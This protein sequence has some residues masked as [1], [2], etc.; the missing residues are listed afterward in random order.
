MPRARL[1]AAGVRALESRATLD[2]FENAMSQ[3]GTNASPGFPQNQL[4]GGTYSYNPITRNRVLLEYAYRG[5]WIVRKCIDCI[6]EDMTRE[7][8]EF[9][10]SAPPDVVEQVSQFW[11]EWGIMQQLHEGITWG[12]LYGGAIGIIII[13]GQDIETRLYPVTV[14]QNQFKGLM[15]LDR[16]MIQPTL[17]QLVEEPGPDF[18][19]PMYYDIYTGS[20]GKVVGRVH[21]TRVIRFEGDPL[22]YWQRQAEN[23]WGASVLEAPYDRF[24]AYDSTT[25]GAAQLVFKAHLRVYKIDKLRQLIGQGGPMLDGLLAQVNFIRFMQTLEG[26]TVIDT[27]DDMQ[28]NTY[29]FAGL[30]DIMLQFGQQLSGALGIPLVRLFGQSPAGLSATGE[31][32]LTNYYD[33]VKAQQEQKLRR[34][35]NLLVDLTYRNVTGFPPPPGSTF[36]FKPLWQ[37]PPDEKVQLGAQVTDTVSKAFESGLISQR[38]ALMELRQSSKQTGIWTN[39]TDEDIEAADDQ[40][41]QPPDDMGGG[42]GPD[43]LPLPQPGETPGDMPPDQEEG[44]ES[45]LDDTDSHVV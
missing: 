20:D 24:I 26:I 29:T 45:P 4:A 8:I 12:R 41:P 42:L 30:S 6:A 43:G 5:S 17:A 37:L 19:K 28:F 2:S 44:P 11:S 27:E 32:D 14:R 15:I 25:L 23:L 18:G 10:S 36:T 7:G 33:H 35:V 31:S 1:T 40:P 21:Y 3:M 9:D 34:Y 13:D 16:W 22:P 39:I 38:T